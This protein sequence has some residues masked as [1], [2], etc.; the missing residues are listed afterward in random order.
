[1]YIYVYIYIERHIYILYICFLSIYLFNL[2][3]Y[4]FIFWH[5]LGRRENPYVKIDGS[6]VSEDHRSMGAQDLDHRI[7]GLK[8]SIWLRRPK[9]RDCLRQERRFVEQEALSFFC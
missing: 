4:I 6:N 1:M 7:K 8:E 9:S 5:I 3:F 2:Y